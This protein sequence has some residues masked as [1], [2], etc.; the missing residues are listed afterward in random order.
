MLIYRRLGRGFL[1]IRFWERIC[2]GAAYVFRENLQ[3]ELEPDSSLAWRASR[4]V[5]QVENLAL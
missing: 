3:V 2:S 5:R 4:V 1:G